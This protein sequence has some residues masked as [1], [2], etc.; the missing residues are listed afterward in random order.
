MKTSSIKKSLPRMAKITILLLITLILPANLW[1][2]LY[3]Q[4]QSQEE[5][6]EEL[7]SQLNQLIENKRKELERDTEDFAE[8]CIHATDMAAYCISLS[9]E[10]VADAESARELARRLDV[11]EIHCFTPDG[12][13][14][15]GTHPKY[16]GYTFDSG[17]QMRYFL[18]M[19]KDKSL[20]LCQ[21]ITPNTAEGKK[22]QYAAVWMEDGSG[23]IQIGMEP[24]RL[25]AEM[26]EQSLEATI[27]EIPID[28]KGFF[29]VLDLN[30]SQIIASTDTSLIGEE[31]GDV[32][33]KKEDGSLQDNF[34]C[35]FGGKKYCVYTETYGDIALIRCY[36]SIYPLKNTVLSTFMVLIYMSLTAVTVIGGI[37]WFVDKKLVVTLIRI[38]EELKR[39]NRGDLKSITEKTNVKELDELIFYMNQ[40]LKS[41]QLGW[42]KLT[43]IVDRGRIPVGLFE[44]NCF[45]G[46]SFV[47]DRL[48]ELLGIE[49]DEFISEELYREVEN[50]LEAVL[51]RPAEDEKIYQ[52]DRDGEETYLKI[53]KQTDEQSVTYYVTDMSMWWRELNEL[54]EQSSRDSLTG[55]Y[56]RRGFHNKM[57]ELFSHQE[58]LGF[59][60]VIMLDADGLKH[61]NDRYGHPIGDEYLKKISAIVREIK[62]PGIV[63][64]RLGGDEFIVFI[65]GYETPEGILEVCQ[66]LRLK[67]GQIFTAGDGMELVEFSIGCAAY[68]ADG[69]N[70]HALM[71]IADERM[72]LE[73]R[74]RKK[75][76]GGGYK[77][78]GFY[79][80]RTHF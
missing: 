24:R 22:M 26:K 1:V 4:H 25:L 52:Y 36:R 51:A 72:Y 7:F 54:R 55:L 45:F 53:E 68:P 3:A 15:A 79:K 12:V 20:K 18:P 10:S 42:D 56:N 27:A 11:D 77:A 65:Y 39:M 46:K 34:H 30:T 8:K 41:I 75:Y 61:I 40:M 80:N 64:A 47:N 67:R 38:V 23:I 76:T 13:I 43:N 21:D 63:S 62:G 9:P 5:S 28:M 78:E 6:S 35:W 17:E 74:E 50:R 19:L 37:T 14:Y 60:A 44:H 16:Y 70:Y 71:Y 66:T 33:E 58:T 2:Q 48:L 49:P 31:L 32:L 73:K 29:H 57:D 69:Q 59:G